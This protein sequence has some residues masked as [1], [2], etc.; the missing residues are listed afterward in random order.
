M[1]SSVKLLS[2]KV[3][4]KTADSN[5]FGII[6]FKTLKLKSVKTARKKIKPCFV[7]G[8]FFPH[9]GKKRQSASALYDDLGPSKPSAFDKV[10]IASWR[11]HACPCRRIIFGIENE[12]NAAF[13]FETTRHRQCY[14]IP[15]SWM[16]NERSW[17]L[18]ALSLYHY[19]ACLFRVSWSASLQTLL[20]DHQ[21]PGK[22]R[23]VLS[24]SS[25]GKART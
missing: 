7:H 1:C 16:V 18:H 17:W 21:T 19:S 23:L 3:S 9:W 4:L 24:S 12:K 22:V 20:R 5:S 14:Q 13:R 25:S 6:T 15:T 11:W 2:W 10:V 8:F